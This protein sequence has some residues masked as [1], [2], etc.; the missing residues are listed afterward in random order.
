MSGPARQT[1]GTPA[2]G[3]QG[4]GGMSNAGSCLVSL[5]SAAIQWRQARDRP[6]RHYHGLFRRRGP[7]AAGIAG[8]QS[9]VVP[10]HVVMLGMEAEPGARVGGVRHT[11]ELVLDHVVGG[12][13]DCRPPHLVKSPPS[14]LT[15]YGQSGN[16]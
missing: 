11:E 15:G 3:R 8:F 16:A 4:G 10:A 14:R 5:P 9:V 7:T 12:A 1:A 2:G 6:I 13:A